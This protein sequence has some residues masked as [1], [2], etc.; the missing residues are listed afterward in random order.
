MMSYPSAFTLFSSPAGT[1]RVEPPDTIVVEGAV[2]GTRSFARSHL[3][4]HRAVADG[5]AIFVQLRVEGED[6]ELLG[7]FP[8]QDGTMIAEALGVARDELLLATP[9]RI[10]RIG[11]DPPELRIHLGWENTRLPIAELLAVTVRQ[12]AGMGSRRTYPTRDWSV[13]APRWLFLALAGGGHDLLGPL[14][15]ADAA[16]AAGAFQRWRAAHPLAPELLD[17]G[18]RDLITA[19]ARFHGRRVRAT[20]EWHLAPEV[21]SFAGVW[22]EPPPDELF[23]PSLRAARV[24]GTWVYPESCA[25]RFGHDERWPGLLLAERIETGTDLAHE[26]V[27]LADYRRFADERPILAA[28][29][30]HRLGDDDRARYAA[31]VEPRDP[32]RAA[33]L[34][35]EATLHAR[36][37]ENPL[38][39]ERFLALARR[40]GLDYARLLIR[41]TLINCGHRLAGDRG[42][43]RRLAFECHEVW[44]ALAPGG[45]A[46]VR[47]CQGC[48]AHV[49]RCE[50]IAEAEERVR[51]GE[52]VAVAKA[53]L[54]DPAARAAGRDPR[55]EW[56]LRLFPGPR[57]RPP[58]VTL[59]AQAG[60]AERTLEAVLGRFPAWSNEASVGA[61]IDRDT[62]VVACGVY[63]YGGRWLASRL[64]VRLVLEPDATHLVGAAAA[65][66]DSWARDSR[67]PREAARAY[68][69]CAAPMRR[70][71][72][73]PALAATLA[74][75]DRVFAEAHAA[76]HRDL[77]ACCTAVRLDGP[78]LR[79]AH[80]GDGCV[81][82]LRADEAGAPRLV[83]PHYLHVP[84]DPTL[85]ILANSLGA[86]SGELRVDAFTVD[87]RAGDLL[88]LASEDLPLADAEIVALV[89]AWRARGEPL[90]RLS[91]DIEERLGAL[92]ECRPICFALA[93]PR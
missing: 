69:D 4:E 70:A 40:I 17:V 1:V 60:E 26:P 5:E 12:H 44:P 2:G 78:V 30:A 93:R 58:T 13:D 33:W 41:D 46:G 87:L 66:P 64:A 52:V 73:R 38:K 14:S 91:E 55:V 54:D 23:A 61:G 34:R 59:P 27:R 71:S 88:L 89:G 21:S 74:E 37:A 47:T 18:A 43:A 51:A 75:V 48:G 39:I 53:L 24:I 8:F 25:G 3:R 45:S 35:L 81:L 9:R 80:V 77:A 83:A 32:E 19:P 7:P 90:V 65:L 49:H 62:L 57:P 82:V 16:L 72:P 92:H 50:T 76:G 28:A 36:A 6:A 86:H 22:L 15:A 20:A 79:G 31:L 67:G 63:G 84:E 42:P 85:R 11:G 10:L 29:A 56:A 68:D